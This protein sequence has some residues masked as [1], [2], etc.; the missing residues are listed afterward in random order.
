[1]A[2]GR[3]AGARTFQVA[4]KAVMCL[5][6]IVGACV[7]YHILLIT[8][9]RGQL[10]YQAELCQTR[11]VMGAM[12]LVPTI[13]RIQMSKCYQVMALILIHTNLKKSGSKHPAYKC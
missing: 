12:L 10:V 9:I 13:E 2:I 6:Q 1:M 11:A 7:L 4:I 5:F 3:G 8:G